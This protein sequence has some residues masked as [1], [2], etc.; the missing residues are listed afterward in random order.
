MIHLLALKEAFLRAWVWCRR[1]WR[2]LLGVLVPVVGLPIVLWL[3]F[4]RGTSN[5]A[6]LLGDVNQ[7]HRKELDAIADAHQREREAVEAARKRRDVTVEQI[8]VDYSIAKVELD[9][10]K[11]EEILKLVERHEDDPEA[12][13]NELARLTGARV[14]TGRKN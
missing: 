14:W 1:R 8:E 7:S 5:I 13:T 9:D 11:R 10:A 2:T 4:R 3:L 6:G 12:L